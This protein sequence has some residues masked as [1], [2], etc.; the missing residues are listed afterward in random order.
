MGSGMNTHKQNDAMERLRILEKAVVNL[1]ESVRKS[2]ARIDSEITDVLGELKA[3][4]LYL[5]RSAPDFK[6]QFPGL[7]QKVK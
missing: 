1:A 6:T 7:R 5:S 3:L 4:K 2:E